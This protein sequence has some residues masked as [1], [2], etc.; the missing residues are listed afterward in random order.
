MKILNYVNLAIVITLIT[1]IILGHFYSYFLGIAFIFG[2]YIMP[3]YHL[4]AGLIWVMTSKKDKR[5]NLYFKGVIIFFILLLCDCGFH[6]IGNQKISEQILTIL[7]RVVPIILATY[8]TYI[9][10]QYSRK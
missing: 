3:I 5:I 9:L 10:N 2:L 7:F 8:F 1:S 4:L 6:K